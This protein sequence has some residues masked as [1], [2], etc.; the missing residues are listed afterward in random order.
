MPR[1]LQFG[2]ISILIPEVCC[3][4]CR[5]APEFVAGYTWCLQKS[6]QNLVT[7]HEVCSKFLYKEKIIEDTLGFIHNHK[8]ERYYAK[9]V[10][11]CKEQNEY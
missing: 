1:K 6:T 4:S 2:K 3:E 9:E 11:T 7:K 10:A 5:F 8:R